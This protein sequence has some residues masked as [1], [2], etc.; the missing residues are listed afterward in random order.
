MLGAAGDLGL[1]AFFRALAL[2]G[3][4]D[5]VD[6]ALALLAPLGQR[7]GDAQVLL[8]LQIAQGQVLELPFDLPHAQPV[9]ERGV[10]PL[11]V[12]G[13]LGAALRLQILDGAHEMHAL[14]QHHQHH[15][16]V[17]GDAEQQPA[18]VLLVLGLVLGR[19]DGLD[20]GELADA[21]QVA[22]HARDPV[23]EA[24]AQLRLAEL[25]LVHAAV[26]QGRDDGLVVHAETR[27]DVRGGQHMTHLGLAGLDAQAATVAG[28]GGA[29]AGDELQRLAVVVGRQVVQP[30]ADGV[31]VRGVLLGEVVDGFDHEE[32]AS[33]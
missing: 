14:G 27:Q 5:V 30:M 1:D 20:V 24:L 11:G 26:E 15:P 29:G 8:W 23:A 3:R 33:A 25:V 9:G 21:R 18:Q 17:L 13:D 10:D 2:D 22:H 31:V 7:P 4:D 32:V 19:D 6:V 16:H 12:M 28:E